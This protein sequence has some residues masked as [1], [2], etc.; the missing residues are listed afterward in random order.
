MICTAQRPNPSSLDV[1][2]TSLD[3]STRSDRSDRGSTMDG[4]SDLE[5][6]DLEEGISN[7]SI[8]S[9]ASSLTASK[10]ND[11]YMEYRLSGLTADA[12]YR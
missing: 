2:T 11:E 1:T 9:E 6:S 10:L 3:G 8:H 7:E 5:E 12:S 4:E